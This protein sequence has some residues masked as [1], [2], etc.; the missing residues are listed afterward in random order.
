[1]P[2]RPD[3]DVRDDVIFPVNLSPPVDH[4]YQTRVQKIKKNTR[5]NV[6]SDAGCIDAYRFKLL[7]MLAD[8]G[9][10]GVCNFRHLLP[11]MQDAAYGAHSE[12]SVT[13]TT[14]RSIVYC[15]GDLEL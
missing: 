6:Q 3:P 14:T 9:P 5:W 4:V 2:R 11:T 10:I 15:V 8:A 12:E 1:M 13:Q 7:D